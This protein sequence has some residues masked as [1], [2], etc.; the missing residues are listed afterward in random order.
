V[1]NRIINLPSNISWDLIDLLTGKLPIL[2][3]Y[4]EKIIGPEYIKEYKLFN[5][6]PR[7]RV[8]HIGCGSYPLSEILLVKL[9]DAKV[10]GID[11]NPKSIERARQVIRRK[12]LIDS[13]DL[14]VENG[15]R[16]PA[17]NF[18]IVIISSCAHPKTLIIENILRTNNRFILREK[19]I[20]TKIVERYLREHGELKIVKEITH[21]PFPFYH[22][23]GWKSYLIE[24]KNL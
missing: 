17:E 20:S 24:K 4:Y 15:V 1:F 21:H 11:I 8:L 5:I 18:D 12:K 23:M 7:S 3:K 6:K 16:Y 13:I 19:E 14:V 22:P 10:T 9:L 2:E